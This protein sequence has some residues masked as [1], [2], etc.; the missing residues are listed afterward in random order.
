MQHPAILQRG[1]PQVSPCLNTQINE[2]HTPLTCDSHSSMHS[3]ANSTRGISLVFTE[4]A[5][6]FE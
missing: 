6:L 5:V 2:N 1:S 3:F 4:H